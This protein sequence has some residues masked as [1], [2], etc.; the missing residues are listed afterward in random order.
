MLTEG[1]VRAGWP[2]RGRL[3][4]GA[5]GLLIPT[6]QLVVFLRR[7]YGGQDGRGSTS[8]GELRWRSISLMVVLGAIPAIARA[9]VAGEG[10]GELPGTQAEARVRVGRGWGAVERPVHGEAG[11]LR[12]GAR[13]R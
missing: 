13:G 6:G 7:C 9:G 2:C 1:L 5:S 8:G 3:M 10:L 11:A 4:Q 12:G